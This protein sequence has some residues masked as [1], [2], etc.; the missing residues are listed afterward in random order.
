MS[1]ALATLWYE[2]QRFPARRAGGRVQRF[3]DRALQ[4]GLLLGLFSITS[5]P[6]DE[7]SADVWIGHPEGP[8]RRSGA[9]DPGGVGIVP[10]HARGRAHRNLYPG[11]RLLGQTHRRFGV[12]R[13]DRLASSRQTP[14][15]RESADAQQLASLTEPGAIIVDESE[16]GRLGIKKVG[17]S[18]EISKQHVRIVSTV[19]GMKSLA[20]PYVF[21]SVETARQRLNLSSSQTMFLLARCRHPEDAKKVVQRMQAYPRKCPRSPAPTSRCTRGFTG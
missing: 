17:D 5:L 6:I 9:T 11:I 21:C 14:S 7:T 10:G 20:G 2:R 13:P 15:G 19:R 16:F 8:E 4:C 18:A 1:Y 12:V 3:A